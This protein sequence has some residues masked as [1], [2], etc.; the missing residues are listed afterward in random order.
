VCQP[1]ALC[2]AAQPSGVFGAF[3]SQEIYLCTILE[4]DSHFGSP[5]RNVCDGEGGEGGTTGNVSGVTV[6]E[7]V[8]IRETPL[9]IRGGGMSEIES[10]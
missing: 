5:S 1:S 3:Y 4:Y 7:D 8:I 10:L 6:A 2:H 9:G